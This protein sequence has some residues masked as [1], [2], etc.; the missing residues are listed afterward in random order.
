MK[1]GTHVQRH[2]PAW[3]DEA[4]L[5]LMFSWGL[6]SVP[7]W[8]P[9]NRR[10]LELFGGA[11]RGSQDA[12]EAFLRSD[13]A[14]ESPYSE[15]YWN[16]L[17]APD[18]PTARHHREVWG[19]RPYESFTTEF[20]AA[21]AAWDPQ[22]WAD[23]AEQSGARYVIPLTKHHDG[24][25]LWPSS[26][27]NP[28]KARW[29][30][31]RDLIGDLSAAVRDRG[32]RFGLYYSGG[33]DWTFGGLPIRAPLDTLAAI[34]RTEEYAA[35]VDAHWRELIERYR[36]SVLW[37]DIG[38][39][40]PEDTEA[41]FAH[42]YEAVPDGVVND[43]FAAFGERAHNDFRTPE[44]S[45]FQEPPPFK[46][47]TVRGLGLSFAHN[48]AESEEHL[49]SSVEL[50]RL[51]AEVVSRGGN[52][53]LGVGPDASGNIPSPQL[54]RLQSL[55]RWL[56]VSGEA[57][58]GTR[59]WVVTSARTDAGTDVFFTTKDGN[60]Y[61]LFVGDPETRHVLR[62]LPLPHGSEARLLG[63]GEATMTQTGDAATLELRDFPPS[64]AQVVRI[65]PPA[66][67][68]L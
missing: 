58:Y 38:H 1:G 35:Y 34:P 18:T 33:L 47:E 7:A 24:F 52:L 22:V 13:V 19:E 65:T 12:V 14:A 41:L 23:A 40:R 56:E 45:G 6:Y 25:L 62:D 27:P 28:H 46:W 49:L 15:W 67:S 32:L 5:G 11:Q 37:N 3:F 39:P 57:I 2:L 61:L 20:Q 48:Q 16:A 9:T 4:K 63:P 59:P 50:V 55:G 10:Y 30:T 54:E 53:L 31:E 29:Q 26:T 64:P 60:L 68:A 44:Y 42:Y 21:A 43:R 51:L 8:A 66:G 17:S 36:P